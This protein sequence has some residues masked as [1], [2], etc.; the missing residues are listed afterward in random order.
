[1][2]TKT[3]EVIRTV[4]CDPFDPVTTSTIIESNSGEN[5]IYEG[6][7]ILAGQ[8]EHLA[9]YEVHEVFFDKVEAA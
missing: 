4:D 8:N 5:A 7:E 6:C 3:Y 2:K 9:S 1:M